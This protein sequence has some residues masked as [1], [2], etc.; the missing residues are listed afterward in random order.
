MASLLRQLAQSK[1]PFPDQVRAL[2]KQHESRKSQ[3]TPREIK[4]ALIATAVEFPRVFII[5]DALDECES[6]DGRQTTLLQ[7]LNSLQE[8]CAANL[9]IT[10]RPIQELS[11]ELGHK[12]TVNIE[13]PEADV[14]KYLDANMHRLPKC[15]SRMNV[16]KQKLFG[17]IKERILRA[18]NGV[19]ACFGLPLDRFKVANTAQL[20]SGATPLR[21]PH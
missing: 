11:A 19:Y 10:S 8:A 4:K 3:P 16:A 20:P 14:A 15:V 18:A 21:I 9:F 5:F 12:V 2:Y 13:V 1:R 7:D 6:S 17:E